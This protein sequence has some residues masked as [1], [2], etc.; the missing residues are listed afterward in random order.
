MSVLPLNE[1]EK[2]YLAGLI[3]GEGCLTINGKNGRM[4]DLVEVLN[5][6]E[7]N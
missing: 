7:G 5:W 6:K 1:V 2:S 3:D 4:V